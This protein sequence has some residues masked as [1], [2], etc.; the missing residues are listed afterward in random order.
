[1]IKLPWQDIREEIDRASKEITIE[2][3]ELI[4]VSNSCIQDQL[5]LLENKIVEI[6]QSSAVKILDSDI[7]KLKRLAV[8]S[9]RGIAFL[10]NKSK[11][12][13]D[14]IDMLSLEID[15][16]KIRK[17]SL[18]KVFYSFKDFISRQRLL[19]AG[20]FLT[21]IAISGIWWLA[22]TNM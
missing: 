11:H 18:S 4:N 17:L 5:R 7:K 22:I 6:D 12:Q 20:I 15:R 19:I 10:E 2:T 13:Q 9:R 8:E 3:H 1:M 21:S 16:L 14:R